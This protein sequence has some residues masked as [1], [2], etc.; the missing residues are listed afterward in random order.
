MNV[1]ILSHKHVKTHYAFTSL[2]Q[3]LLNCP[4][5]IFYT[6]WNNIRAFLYRKI[7]KEFPCTKLRFLP[8]KFPQFSVFFLAKTRNLGASKTMWEKSSFETFLH[9]RIVLVMPHS[10]AKDYIVTCH[11]TGGS[12]VRFLPW[13]WKFPLSRASMVSPP[14]KLKMFTGNVCV[15][16]TS[17]SFKLLSFRSPAEK[18]NR[19]KQTN[20]LR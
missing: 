16:L 11:W 6:F 5:Q 3:R 4:S 14:S 19:N 15:L 18:T 10:S 13:A 7:Y 17:V 2:K 8:S 12:G 1:V 9:F 20:T